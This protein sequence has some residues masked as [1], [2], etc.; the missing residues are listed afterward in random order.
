MVRILETSPSEEEL[1]KLGLFNLKKRGLTGN[2][3]VIV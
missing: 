3:I 1:N 2:M